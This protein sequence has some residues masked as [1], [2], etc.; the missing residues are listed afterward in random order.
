[1]SY[2]F[3]DQSKWSNFCVTV[4]EYMRLHTHVED[5]DVQE[6]PVAA[7]HSHGVRRE[8]EAA[9]EDAPHAQDD[10]CDTSR[11]FPICFTGKTNVEY[12]TPI[13]VLF[14]CANFGH[15]LVSSK[16][17][18]HEE[19]PP[20][21]LTD[22]QGEEVGLVEDEGDVTPRE[23]VKDGGE[24]LHEPALAVRHPDV[25]DMYLYTIYTPKIEMVD[26]S[27]VLAVLGRGLG[28][29]PY[30]QVVPPGPSVRP[31]K[32]EVWPKPASLQ[33][34]AF[35]Y[36]LRPSSFQFLVSGPCDVLDEAVTRYE[37]VLA[38]EAVVGRALARQQQRAGR[39]LRPWR[40]D[41]FFGGYITSLRVEVN[42]CEPWPYPHME[43]SYELVVDDSMP[44]RTPSARLVA[45]SSWGAL[46]GLETFVQLLSS[47]GDGSS[48]MINATHV[49]D[50]PRFP[51]RGLLID[52][53]RH[54][55]PVEDIKLELD[56]MEAVKMNVLHWHIV[57]DQSF[58]WQSSLFPE[59]SEKGA[60]DPSMTYSPKDVAD[61]IQY[62]RLRGIRVLPEF[63]T[64]GH[65]RSWGEGRP[66]LLAA[67]HD[68]Q[69]RPDG[70]FS[71]IDPTKAENRD[72][73]KSLFR[74]VA[75]TFPDPLLHLGGD[76]V[77][78]FCWNSD[79]SVQAYMENHG[80]GGDYRRLQ[81]DYLRW[82]TMEVQR[83][84]RTPVVWQEAW[85]NGN[86][87]PD[88]V[89]VH[90]WLGNAMDLMN[91]VTRRG[92]RALLSE[93]WY[94]DHL[95]TDWRTMYR[96]DPQNFHGRAEQMRLV[97]GGEACMWGEMADETNVHSR[98]WPRAAAVAERLWSP[99]TTTDPG[100]AAVRLE[101]LVCRLRRRGVA[102]SPAN[103][104]G[105]CPRCFATFKIRYGW[106]KD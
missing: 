43:E 76:E 42:V 88:D 5:V 23:L 12:C 21:T 48:L 29:S 33:R 60:Y 100:A 67:C 85:Q 95:G 91:Q 59:L 45:H 13:G 101:E 66:G 81:S 78:D 94:L 69:G 51:H 49:A 46:R 68:A 56:A 57:D 72:F 40:N 26:T 14:K 99:R 11:F 84:N 2:V 79:P 36:N 1:M 9:L 96:V 61:V 106:I 98:V 63:D 103:G 15:F 71:N 105:Y 104:P 89:I 102:A 92:F 87:D 6:G 3:M 62:A 24:H 83:L 73:L 80:F 82:L 8:H 38:H 30:L 28:Q 25:L 70:T 34:S 65:T 53:S 27:L 75:A 20:P 86:F 4:C 18:H 32:G 47:S 10:H 90:I 37:R 44:N 22:S 7:G 58:P 55:L 50:S 19:R 31:S 64:P 97:E 17:K 16:T 77:P 39:R 35:F 52:T 93:T 54:F 41:P 74:E